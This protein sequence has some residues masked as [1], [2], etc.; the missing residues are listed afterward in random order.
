MVR[1]CLPWPVQQSDRAQLRQCDATP[2]VRRSGRPQT[3]FAL[4][5][6]L[7]AEY[8]KLTLAVPAQPVRAKQTPTFVIAGRNRSAPLNRPVYPRIHQLRLTRPP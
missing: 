3:T 8:S 5:A 6:V 1:G 4:A 7:I 2:V